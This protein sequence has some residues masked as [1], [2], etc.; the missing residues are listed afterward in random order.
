MRRGVWRRGSGLSRTELNRKYG[1][2]NITTQLSNR[3][4]SGWAVVVKPG[5]GAREGGSGLSSGVRAW[6]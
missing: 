3:V 6:V 2:N 4:G 1:D 5:S